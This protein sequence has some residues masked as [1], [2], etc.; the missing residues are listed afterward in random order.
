MR[1]M[2]RLSSRIILISS[3][4]F[5][6]LLG[7]N[8][9]MM[10]YNSKQSVQATMGERT[11][12]IAKNMAS[13][14]DADKFKELAN[15]PEENDLYWELREQLNELRE[16]NGVLYAYTYAIPKEGEAVRFLVD[17]MPVDDTENAATLGEESSSTT[18]EHIALVLEKGEYYSE[19]LSGTY[20]EYISGTIPLQTESGEVVAL[21]GVDIDAS[22]VGQISGTIAKEVLPSI[23]AIF[24]LITFASLFALYYYVNRSLRPLKSLEEASDLLAQGDIRGASET[25][26]SINKNAKNEITVFTKAFSTTLSQLTET[27]TSIHNKTA[28]LESAVD[29]INE[30]TEKVGKS[31]SMI[32]TNIME[33]ATSSDYQKT[34]NDEVMLAMNEMAVGISRLA[35]TTNTIASS[36]SEMT[37]L[38]DASVKDSYEVINQ[39]QNV[40]AS[41]VRTSEHVREMGNK[42]NTIEEMISVITNIAD[43]TNL[44]ALNA[45]IEAARAGEAGK[46]FAVVADEVRKLAEM[47]RSSANDIHDHLQSFLGITGRALQEMESS[48]EDV[49]AGNAAVASIGEKLERILVSVERVNNQIQEDSAV[50]EQMSAGSQQILATA[51]EMH[52]YVTNNTVQ[53]REVASSTDIQVEMVEKLN[54]VVKRLDETSSDVVKE[55]EKFKL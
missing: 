48:T 1:K 3:I 13:Y 18:Y 49:K 55:I 53:T 4:I 21:L 38:V 15:N 9:L 34:S 17:G 32:A 10:F 40:E 20:G 42:F 43:Q 6:L 16:M 36:S 8:T 25:V 54:G 50:I 19:L 5:L 28:S 11:V 37:Q 27:F 30:S 45:A 2:D 52:R 24:V 14:I 33:I 51:E 22:Y 44:L 29:D 7:L 47:S 35:D 26:S 12:S 23:I 39:I 46:G 31:S 41:V